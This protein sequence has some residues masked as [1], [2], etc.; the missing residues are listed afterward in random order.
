MHRLLELVA[1]LYHLLYLHNT[2]YVVKYEL[3]D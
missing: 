1:P 2:L 3:C